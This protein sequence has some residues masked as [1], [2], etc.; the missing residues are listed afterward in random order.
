VAGL[1]QKLRVVHERAQP[2]DADPMMNFDQRELL[3]FAQRPGSRSFI[4]T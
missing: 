3:K 4:S 2:R 1:V